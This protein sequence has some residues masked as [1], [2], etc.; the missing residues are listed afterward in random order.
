MKSIGIDL[1]TSNTR[2]FLK[3]KGIV[4]R[5]PS[6]V[7]VAELNEE[8]IAV[9][10][11]ASR[12]AG[13]TPEDVTVRRPIKSGVI[14]QFDASV[15]MVD[16]FMQK[17]VGNLSFHHPRVMVCVPYSINDVEKR[18][19][20]EVILEAGAKSVALIESSMT[21]AIGAG[22]RVT[23]P[24]GSMIV[25]IGGGTTEIAVMS[26][27][28][29]VESR[30]IRAA[31]DAMDEAI[32]DYIRRKFNVMVSETTAEYCK[33]SIGIAQ[34]R[35]P[36]ST[37]PVKDMEV[38]GR[39]VITGLPTSIRL[40]GDDIAAAISEV[41]SQIEDAIREALENTPPE[42][43]A[44]LLEDGIVL[45]GGGALL[46]GLSA[47]ISRATHLKVSIAKNPMDCSVLGFGRLLEYAGDVDRIIRFRTK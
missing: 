28:A 35:S 25:D 24:R 21:A 2:I 41:L 42:L 27:G 7:A 3:G 36:D 46:G 8:V 1:G 47:R 23:H 12:M 19:V 13:K 9:G 32:C 4:L 26:L 43:A 15:A 44:D 18:A 11:D 45:S 40:T 37:L 5:E 38:R 10:L 20:E 29:I 16:V 34:K 30:S 6:A 33:R 39:N 14:A 17:A 22:L 31:G